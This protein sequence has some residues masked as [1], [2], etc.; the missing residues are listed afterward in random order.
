MSIGR[1]PIAQP[2][3]RETRARPQRAASGPSTRLDARMVLTSSYGA[4]GSRLPLARMEY[5][6]GRGSTSAPTLASRLAIVRMSTTFGMRPKIT[7]P[8][9]SR[10]AAKA[11]SAA[12]LA[13]LISM[14]PLSGRPPAIRIACMN[15]HP[16]AL[17]AA[18]TPLCATASTGPLRA[19]SRWFERPVR[20][21]LVRLLA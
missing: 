20:N 3:G 19:C 8:S 12:F 7:G 11:G 14:R 4:T 10:L 1:D 17:R 21:P 18:K 6:L 15:S 13:P 5:E 2:P 9:V 16:S